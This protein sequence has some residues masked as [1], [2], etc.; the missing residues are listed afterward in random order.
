M[1]RVSCWLKNSNPACCTT[2]VSQSL[3]PNGVCTAAKLGRATLLGT[4]LLRAFGEAEVNERLADEE[5]R[6]GNQRT[7]AIAPGIRERC[8]ESAG[9]CHRQGR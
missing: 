1:A 6:T 5:E 3:W 9:S 7:R 2:G 4:P 8:R